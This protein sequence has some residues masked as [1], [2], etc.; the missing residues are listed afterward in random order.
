[1]TRNHF[2][3]W[4]VPNLV[5]FGRM[6]CDLQCKFCTQHMYMRISSVQPFLSGMILYG[7]AAACACRALQG[8]ST[9]L[10]ISAT[11]HIEFPEPG[12]YAVSALP[13]SK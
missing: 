1:M 10:L 11:A 4:L 12:S 6:Q 5:T 13:R 2:D 9:T 7:H 8:K 3:N